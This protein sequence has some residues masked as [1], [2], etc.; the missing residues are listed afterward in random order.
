M[1]HVLCGMP[2]EN[3]ADYRGDL[4]GSPVVMTS[5]SSA[6]SVHLIPA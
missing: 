3:K 5:S 1:V 2:V 4:P 6:G